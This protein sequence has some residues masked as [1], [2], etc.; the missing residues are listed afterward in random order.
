MKQGD[1]LVVTLQG[2]SA[3]QVVKIASLRIDPYLVSNVK[4]IHAVVK[5]TLNG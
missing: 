2:H 3:P 4:A 1:Y 5:G